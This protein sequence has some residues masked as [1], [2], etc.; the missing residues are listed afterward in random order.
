MTPR[1]PEL[2]SLLSSLDQSDT[3]ATQLLRLDAG[4]SVDALAEVVSK[5]IEDMRTVVQKMLGR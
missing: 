4:P 5:A 2:L 1:L 3:A